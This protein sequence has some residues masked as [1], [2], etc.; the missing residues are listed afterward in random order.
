MRRTAYRHANA[1]PDVPISSVV[2]G[3]GV[4]YVSGH[5]PTDPATGAVVAGTIEAQTRATLENIKASLALAGAALA[6]VV[7]VNVFL[8]DMSEFTAMNSVYREY[9]P[10]EPPARTTVGTSGLAHPDMRIEIE[11]IALAPES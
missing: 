4:L 1:R 5:V 9:F 11:A 3:D 10:S 6:D 8:T 7:K 2:R